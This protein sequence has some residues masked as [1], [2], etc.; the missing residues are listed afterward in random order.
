[1]EITFLSS[2]INPDSG[3]I[4]NKEQIDISL[5]L[6]DLSATD[7]RGVIQTDYSSTSQVITIPEIGLMNSSS[8]YTPIYK[9][10]LDYNVW[11]TRI[12]KNFEELD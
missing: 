11:L 10:K 2:S 9:E 8:Y 12:N 1:M 6:F 3:S 4:V 5:S 7:D